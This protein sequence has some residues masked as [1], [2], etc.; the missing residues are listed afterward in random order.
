MSRIGDSI[1]RLR[2]LPRWYAFGFLMASIWPLVL[3]YRYPAVALLI[4]LP[5]FVL[6]FIATTRPKAPMP[7]AEN[8]PDA[9]P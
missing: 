4:A 9:A 3:L 7:P 1:V 2:A 8:T 5:A 6:F